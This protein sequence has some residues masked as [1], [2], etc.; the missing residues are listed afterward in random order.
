MGNIVMQVGTAIEGAM[1]L[2]G[3]WLLIRLE[4]LP[5]SKQYR[6]PPELG[7]WG[8]RADQFFMYLWCVLISVFVC[9]LLMTGIVKG[10]H[11]QGDLGLVI[12]GA[13][14]HPGILL[15]FLSAK[16]FVFKDGFE[17]P[18]PPRI[19]SL[20]T[21]TA[22]FMVSLPVIFIAMIA[23]AALIKAL[24]WPDDQQEL[25]DVFS[26]PGGLGVKLLIALLAVCVAPVSEELLFRG[27]LF[28]FM[29]HRT[30]R[31]IAYLVPALLFAALHVTWNS[32]TRSVE[33]LTAVLPLT[34]LAILFSIAYERTGRIS[35]PMIAHALFN[36]N[37]LV[38]T[39]AHVFGK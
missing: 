13:A 19:P 2:A 10:L 34:T 39:S 32:H 30:P 12:A 23:S 28:R 3:L 26:G 37:E 16:L 1:A 24:G 15:G 36:L 38:M 20:I 11:L 4:F 17:P 8:I 29:L 31:W 6:R 27:G 5:S 18:A 9:S 7:K 14:L 22:T 21:G 33:G 25:I 35:T